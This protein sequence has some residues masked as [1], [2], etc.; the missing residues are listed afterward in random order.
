MGSNNGGP[1]RPV[2]RF[3]DAIARYGIEDCRP[4][5]PV[6]NRD[7]LIDKLTEETRPFLEAIL[8]VEEAEDR[9]VRAEDMIRRYVGSNLSVVAGLERVRAQEERR[10]ALAK[11]RELMREEETILRYVLLRQL[12]RSEPEDAEAPAEPALAGSA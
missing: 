1:D 11:L 12:L 9:L 8:E 6:R 4:E 7:R 2:E 5:R 10:T 3:R